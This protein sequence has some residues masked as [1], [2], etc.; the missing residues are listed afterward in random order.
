MIPKRPSP[1]PVLPPRF[2]ATPYTLRHSFGAHL[3]QNGATLA[4]VAALLGDS[5][6]VTEAHYAGLSH[7][8][9]DVILRLEK[10]KPAPNKRGAKRRPRPRA[11]NKK[12]P[13]QASAETA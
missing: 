9:H 8:E 6:S 1:R 10:P 2:G 3:V 7:G 13:G 5:L 4:Q 11:T 12:R